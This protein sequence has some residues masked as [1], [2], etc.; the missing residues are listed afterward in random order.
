V[1][2]AP[3]PQ[4][5][6]GTEEADQ[7]TPVLFAQVRDIRADVQDFQRSLTRL[8]TSAD[9]AQAAGNNNAIAA[10]LSEETPL[11]TRLRSNIEAALDE[12]QQDVFRRS[13]KL[14]SDCGDEVTHINNLWNRVI[15]DWPTTDDRDQLTPRLARLTT[16]L[17]EI[18]IHTARLTVANRLNAHLETVRIGKAV[19]FDAAFSDEIPDAADRATILSYLAD[20]PGAVHGVTDTAR[21]LV[22]RVSQNQMIR[23]ATY[24]T[25]VIAAALA[26]MVAWAAGKID[27]WL[28]LDHWPA[29]M[30]NASALLTGYFFVLIGAIVHVAVEALKQ[31]RFGAGTTFLALDDLLDWLHIR[32]LSISAS[33]LWVL[34]GVF[35][36]AATTSPIHWSTAFF[37]GYSID[38]LG[39]LFL[40]RFGQAVDRQTKTIKDLLPASTSAT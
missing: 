38:S 12:I 40:Q 20:H 27:N 16:N 36:L 6:P 28:T 32:Y 31:Q 26:A 25:P 37:V 11:I 39:G 35:G 34:V 2:A 19:N 17:S 3:P 18:L 7:L 23:I 29:G 33:V 30:Q 22:F 8:T 24:L 14:W 1:A 15:S 13:P 21:G 10:A 9:A 5:R 4:F